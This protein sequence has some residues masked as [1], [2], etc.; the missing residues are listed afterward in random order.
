MRLLEDTHVQDP[1]R[2]SRLLALLAPAF[3]WPFV[4]GLWEARVKQLKPKKHGRPP[5]SVPHCGY[6]FSVV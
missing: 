3:A 6:T 2:L 1:E 4:V 5:K